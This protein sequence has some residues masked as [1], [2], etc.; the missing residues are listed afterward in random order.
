MKEHLMTDDDISPTRDRKERFFITLSLSIERVMTLRRPA[1]PSSTGIS[2]GR[3]NARPLPFPESPPSHTPC[4]ADAMHHS[5]DALEWLAV[6]PASALARDCG[7]GAFSHAGFPRGCTLA[8]TI[9]ATS[10]RVDTR[11]AALCLHSRHRARR[12]ANPIHQLMRVLRISASVGFEEPL[13]D[14]GSQLLASGKTGTYH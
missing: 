12:V 7:C 8:V 9:P 5:S 14:L 13:R 3:D 10:R 11:N 6:T 1:Q 4:P 2:F